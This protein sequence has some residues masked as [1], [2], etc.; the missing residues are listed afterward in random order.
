MREP[1]RIG[2]VQ[3]LLLPPMSQEGRRF[4]ARDWRR[5]FAMARSADLAYLEWI[6]DLAEADR[7]PL[8]T[9]FGL[10]EIRE[11]SARTGVRVRSVA[12][13]FLTDQP[14]VDGQGHRMDEA[15][16]QLKWLIGR[17]AALGALQI[18]INFDGPAKLT[19]K[20]QMRA[21]ADILRDVG[22]HAEM[23]GV[24]LH[25][26]TGLV[27]PTVA[28]FMQLLDQ[29]SIKAVFDPAQ[30][31]GLEQDPLDALVQIEPWLGAIYID[32][33]LPSGQFVGL[34]MGVVNY[35]ALFAHLAARHRQPWFT[36]R[37]VRDSSL[38][39]LAL[40]QRNR[41]AVNQMW[42]KC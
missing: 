32:D 14:L 22:F 31:I 12:A 6:Y 9:D 26:R 38:S 36:L 37:P 11:L 25:L 17:V 42:L 34:G 39:E 2:I 29:T 18:V 4:P 7:N 24:E 8:A 23:A 28:K 20:D 10:R 3:D 16:D 33:A 15:V 35:R 19:G 1:A 27:A 30:C 21:L 40:A 41:R 5:E 13:D